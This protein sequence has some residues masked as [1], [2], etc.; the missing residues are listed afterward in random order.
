MAEGRKLFIPGVSSIDCEERFVCRRFFP[1]DQ[2]L[3]MDSLS[4]KV[5]TALK[6][7]SFPGMFHALRISPPEIHS[8]N[9]TVLK[10]V[11]CTDSGQEFHQYMDIESTSGVA[12]EEDDLQ[13]AW[14]IFFIHKMME[15]GGEFSITGPG[16]LSRSLLVNLDRYAEAWNRWMPETFHR[17]TLHTPSIREDSAV[18][19]QKD[20]ISCF[21]GGL[22]A[23]FTAY[24][25]RKGLAGLQNLNLAACVMFQGADIKEGNQDH[26]EK[27]FNKAAELLQDIGIRQF[28]RLRTNFRELE[29]DYEMTYHTMLMGGMRVFTSRFGYFMAA[30]EGSYDSFSYPWASN[31]ITD[32]YLGSHSKEAVTDGMGFD[33]TE[34]AAV[35]AGW[36]KAMRLL[37]CCW[38]GEDQ[39]GNCGV[40][41]KC[42]L[43]IMNFMA[44][45]VP[46]DNILCMPRNAM[47]EDISQIQFNRPFR[48]LYAQEILRH[49]KANGLGQEPWVATLERRLKERNVRK[50]GFGHKI[51]QLLHFR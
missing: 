47:N 43:T 9:R 45:G 38:E 2:N 28:Y 35:V 49:A 31:P 5:C 3:T 22:D 15:I 24:R 1:P 4:A 10:A 27:A 20:A 46:R 40:C 11:L 19:Q 29:T 33:R 39:S 13:D 18:P 50:T 14:C 32:H 16:K 7:N 30:S 12:I 44:M 21:S 41:T 34:K 36:D 51:R 26:F 48:V 25:H 17:I 42:R 6:A 8:P 37:R 23:C